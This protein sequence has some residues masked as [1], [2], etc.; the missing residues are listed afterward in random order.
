MSHST[1]ALPVI[2]IVFIQEAPHCT[3]TDLD[4]L[5]LMKENVFKHYST[6]C[7]EAEAE[8]LSGAGV[9]ILR[10]LR[11]GSTQTW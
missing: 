3:D 7:C 6:Q 10:W 4:T 8:F 9:K 1:G 2:Q 5:L 11:F